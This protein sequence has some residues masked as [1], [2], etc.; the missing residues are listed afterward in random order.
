M[1]LDALLC[2]Y[3]V[4]GAGCVLAAHH[5]QRSQRLRGAHATRAATRAI[6]AALLGLLWP[7]Y[8]P[9]LL[10][11]ERD[12]EGGAHVEDSAVPDTS[13]VTFLSALRRARHT[14]LGAVLPD[15]ATA[16]ALAR[17]L[18]VAAAKVREIDALLA[19]PAFDEE[20]A[21]R[22]LRTLR[23]REDQRR[24][25]SA[26]AGGTADPA[27]SAPLSLSTAAL[28]L[29]NIRRLRALRHRF[30]SELDDVGELLIQLTTQAEVLRL[31]GPASPSAGAAGAPWGDEDAGELV[32]ELVSRVEGLDEMLDDDPH[33]LDARA[34]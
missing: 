19:Q 13:E 21:A 14:P 25:A 31:A 3:A 8:G 17:R 15:E 20:A 7:L 32:R 2:L 12:G 28:R 27:P 33:L 24:G 10:L 9:L 4:V 11:R 1:S 16:Q 6:D 29:Q 22:R 18:R 23:E 34:S 5:A 26:A 30:A